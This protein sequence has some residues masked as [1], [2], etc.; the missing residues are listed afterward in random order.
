MQRVR[1]ST[2]DLGSPSNG[3]NSTI[4][5]VEDGFVIRGVHKQELGMSTNDVQLRGQSFAGN[6]GP[7]YRPRPRPHHL[8]K[9]S[10][11]ARLAESR[12]WQPGPANQPRWKVTVQLARLAA[13]SKLAGQK[14]VGAAVAN[15]I[16]VKKWKAVGNM[17]KATTDG[18]TRIRALVDR[19]KK[20]YM[21]AAQ[22]ALR[23]AAVGVLDVKLTVRS[24]RELQHLSYLQQGD[25]S[26]YTAEALAQRMAIR[27]QPRFREAVRAWWQWLPLCTLPADQRFTEEEKLMPLDMRGMTK[28]VYCAMAAIIQ[29]VLL[30]R[31]GLKPNPSY[32]PEED[33]NF[34]CR[35]K[36]FLLFPQLLNALFELADMWCPTISEDDYVAILMELLGQ[37]KALEGRHGLFSK[38]LSK[39]QRRYGAQ[40]EHKLPISGDYVQN[41]NS[42]TGRAVQANAIGGGAAVPVAAVPVPTGGSAAVAAAGGDAA[43]ALS[44]STAAAAAALMPVPEEDEAD[45]V[46][47]AL[48]DDD[49]EEDHRA[50]TD[51]WAKIM[52]RNRRFMEAKAN[53]M[54]DETAEAAA[55]NVRS[56]LASAGSDSP[57]EPLQ[58]PMAL[59]GSL[60]D[61]PPASA[62]R[63][64]GGKGTA[65]PLSPVPP[66]TPPP[67]HK[68]TPA[69]RMGKALKGQT[70]PGAPSTAL[71]ATLREAVTDALVEVGATSDVAA[72]ASVLTEEGTIA[73]QQVGPHT[74][75]ELIKV[76][77]DDKRM[78][79]R[80]IRA[81]I[82]N[83][84]NRG[85]PNGNGNGSSPGSNAGSRVVSKKRIALSAFAEFSESSGRTATAAAVAMAAAVPTAPTAPAMPLGGSGAAAISNAS[86]SVRQSNIPSRR[87]GP[88]E[89]GDDG[90]GGGTIGGVVSGSGAGVGHTS[91]VRD[92]STPS[93]VWRGPSTPTMATAGNVIGVGGSSG[94]TGHLR[95]PVYDGSTA[96]SATAATA[97]DGGGGDGG[98]RSP[99]RVITFGPAE[100]AAVADDKD[101]GAGGSDNGKGAEEGVAA[102]EDVTAYDQDEADVGVGGADVGGDDIGGPPQVFAARPKTPC[103]DAATLCAIRATLQ[104]AGLA[105]EELSGMLA[106]HGMGLAPEVQPQVLAHVAKVLAEAGFN[107]E[108]IVA[109][110]FPPE[111]EE[112][113]EA[114]GLGLNLPL[115]EVQLQAMRVALSKAGVDDEIVDLVRSWTADIRAIQA[116][117]AALEASGFTPLE[118]QR[119]IAPAASTALIDAL[120]RRGLTPAAAATLLR[121]DG[122]GL[123]LDLSPQELAEAADAMAVAGFTAEQVV[124]AIG[125][126][127][128]SVPPLEPAGLD[129]CREALL[130]EGFTEEE[131]DEVVLADNGTALQDSIGAATMARVAMALANN[132]LTS[133]TI[134][135]FLRYDIV[136]ASQSRLPKRALRA[137]Q[138]VV[139]ETIRYRD[140]APGGLDDPLLPDGS[141]VA[142]DAGVGML[143]QIGGALVEAMFKPSQIRAFLMP[144]DEAASGGEGSVGG[145]GGTDNAN[146]AAAQPQELDPGPLGKPPGRSVSSGVGRTR[147]SRRQYLSPRDV[148]VFRSVLMASGFSTQD[149]MEIVRP[150][151]RCLDPDADPEL[152]AKA[153]A[154]L[155]AA[156]FKG[157]EIQLFLQLRDPAVA[158]TPSETAAARSALVTAGFTRPQL[159]DLLRRDGLGLVSDP[160]PD[161]YVMS[162]VA[163]VLAG[164][165]FPTFHICQYL[166]PAMPLVPVRVLAVGRYFGQ[167]ISGNLMSYMSMRSN[168][169]AP[170]DKPWTI[171]NTTEDGRLLPEADVSDD[172]EDRKAEEEAAAALAATVA[173]RQRKRAAAAAGAAMEAEVEEEQPDADPYDWVAL[174]SAVLQAMR[175]AVDRRCKGLTIK[176]LRQLAPQMANPATTAAA[177]AA[178]GPATV[179]GSWLP[180][181][182]EVTARVVRALS[183]EGFSTDQVRRFFMQPVA[184]AAA[185]GLREAELFDHVPPALMF[186]IRA[187][188]KSS[189]FTDQHLSN[190]LSDDRR[191]LD[192]D[193]DVESAV[194]MVSALARAGFSPQLIR[195]LLTTGPPVGALTPN[196]L[197]TINEALLQAGFSRRQLRLVL[198]H[199]HSGPGRNVDAT[200]LA[201]M[202]TAISQASCTAGQLCQ[203]LGPC[204]A[205]FTKPV[206]LPL[207]SPLLA[208]I[209]AP[210]TAPSTATA[211]ST[212]LT[213]S[214]AGISPSASVAL[215]NTTASTSSGLILPIGSLNLSVS[216]SQPA[217]QSGSGIAATGTATVA[218]GAVLDSRSVMDIRNVAASCGFSSRVLVDMIRPD[219][220]GL[221]RHADPRVIDRVGLHMVNQGFTP[222]Q[223]YRFL[224]PH[225]GC[226]YGQL[227]PPTASAVRAVLLAA[228]FSHADLK[229]LLVNG[230]AAIT[231]NASAATL[232]ALSYSLAA[233]GASA[234]QIRHLLRPPPGAIFTPAA[235]PGGGGDNVSSLAVTVLKG[236][237]TS[238]YEDHQLDLILRKDGTAL[239]ADVGPLRLAQMVAALAAADVSASAIRLFVRPL[240]GVQPA[241]AVSLKAALEQCPGFDRRRVEAA[242]SPETYELGPSVEPSTLADIATAL[243][244]S[245]ISGEVI[246][247]LISLPPGPNPAAAPQ[248]PPQAD[249]ISTTP[250]EAPVPVPAPPAVA[251]PSSPA[252]LLRSRVAG[253]A[254]TGRLHPTLPY[255]KML[256]MRET[257][258]SR[259]ADSTPTPTELMEMHDPAKVVVALADAGYPSEEIRA[260]VGTDPKLLN[261]PAF[262]RSSGPLPPPAIAAAAMAVASGGSGSGF[263]AAVLNRGVTPVVGSS[264]AMA[265]MRMSDPG[266]V[267]TNAKLRNPLITANDRNGSNRRHTLSLQAP[268]TRFTADGSAFVEREPGGTANRAAANTLGSISE[269][270]SSAAAAAPP[271][272]PPQGWADFEYRLGVGGSGCGSDGP[273]AAVSYSAAVMTG[274]DSAAAEALAAALAAPLTAEQMLAWL[275]GVRHLVPYGRMERFPPGL[276][277]Q[278]A[279]YL[280]RVL[281]RLV[282]NEVLRVAMN[283]ATGVSAAPGGPLDVV[284][285]PTDGG[286]SP[287][288]QAGHLPGRRDSKPTRTRIVIK[289]LTVL[290]GELLRQPTHGLEAQSW[291][292][293][294]GGAGEEGDCTAGC[295]DG[296][297]AARAAAISYVLEAVLSKSHGNGGG[298]L[299][300]NAVA[301][302]VLRFL[303]LS[304]V[305]RGVLPS[306]EFPPADSSEITSSSTPRPLYQ[307]SPV[308]E[309]SAPP[310]LGRRNSESRWTPDSGALRALPAG[311]ARAWGEAPSTHHNHR[312]GSLEGRSS[313][314]V[315]RS[316]PQRNNPSTAAAKA[317]SPRETLAPWPLQRA[318][319]HPH[320]APSSPLHPAA[321]GM[322]SYGRL[323]LELPGSPSG[324]ASPSSPGYALRPTAA[325]AAAAAA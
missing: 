14:G 5:D 320:P 22:E 177:A 199:D 282:G 283:E 297:L 170:G 37:C 28:P 65:P 94:G 173:E 299:P 291:S 315:Y 249:T 237:M 85:S 191:R 81:L 69:M 288:G 175:E 101:T 79:T 151:G 157:H 188:L 7:I 195:L 102:T 254:A 261:S 136:R 63:R 82:G 325:T 214:I 48:S 139:T 210:V 270:P 262:M 41:F 95:N 248:P 77:V 158:M 24:E 236:L 143:A 294:G 197:G 265:P 279:S 92:M 220:R 66:P 296:V 154:A 116:T 181:D 217:L 3:S 9:E 51:W 324:L 91:G 31:F 40:D 207:L 47:K 252:P 179:G 244:S 232:A 127:A 271:P 99:T 228:G 21:Q 190:L 303:I 250:P 185:A 64:G 206:P 141:G 222:A 124:Q 8:S 105:S 255:T 137:M 302:T 174:P 300:A 233:S 215:S 284:P 89:L 205:A 281:L 18:V 268:A 26:M 172:E 192:P 42:A 110:L 212:I 83:S 183:N 323:T 122:K 167:G 238:G 234:D 68:T 201:Q 202:A 194:M 156:G 155:S 203:F 52:E 11:D 246:K 317:G 242:F 60:Y 36:R 86:G 241:V 57:S 13:H 273:T 225:G 224:L 46:L 161:P 287:A 98:P 58:F 67:E 106:S 10:T 285:E 88:I 257:I 218:A 117:S 286:G 211:S 35:G 73:Y 125:S 298:G 166:A 109:F 193:W 129:T 70:A 187:L 258:L 318:F 198:R 311:Y 272:S 49:D 153:V 147:G 33:W 144:E 263:V 160:E 240:G 289:L 76:L 120:R 314:L 87:V 142:P 162:Q 239:R 266:F 319:V 256:A 308:A 276:E 310:S 12:T 1:L 93:A 226:E 275:A 112:E 55:A 316:L 108:A 253:A 44:S 135:R 145:D 200:T 305:R 306:S 54:A 128:A 267:R 56:S 62:S 148:V 277:N 132:G 134:R 119:F 74:L 243:S 164:A 245:G 71:V 295:G 27:S 25:A 15:Q 280:R 111:A 72:A 309:C 4:G 180:L 126:D 301:P 209:N 6:S 23:L 223:I 103:M 292:D 163:V 251:P 278:F 313:P 231:T 269:Q 178:A 230:N 304:A 146:A 168:S 204:P 247:Q 130:S 29:R 138:S 97:T 208:L 19:D 186:L 219:G 2:P 123:S 75:A 235:A 43:A 259:W 312:S 32:A 196:E 149:L 104:C 121:R 260:F 84:F 159:E 150:D 176:Q 61:T 20:S 38:L 229:N 274:S 227:D 290:L 96:A 307:S 216:P 114:V 39:Y 169:Q 107:T 50:T 118:V 53:G 17:M 113:L 45:T 34:D 293:G 184:A 16:V 152:A 264:G 90:G 221:Q 30:P 189:G 133:E 322:S 80:H 171:V 165:G 321:G 100:A 78:N 182:T 213:A 140:D 59:L 115:S 131:L